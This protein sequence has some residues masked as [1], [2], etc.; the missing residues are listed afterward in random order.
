MKKALIIHGLHTY[1]LVLCH[2]CLGQYLSSLAL[3]A[4][5]HLPRIHLFL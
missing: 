1:A 2:S 4:G 5:E 3:N